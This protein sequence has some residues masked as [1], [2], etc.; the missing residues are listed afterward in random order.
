MQVHRRG[1]DGKERWGWGEESQY[2]LAKERS[3][4]GVP[5]KCAGWRMTDNANVSWPG[6]RLYQGNQKGETRGQFSNQRC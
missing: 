4:S 6:D 3:G 1:G 5:H 2:T